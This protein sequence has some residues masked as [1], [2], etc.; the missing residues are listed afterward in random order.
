MNQRREEEWL[1]RDFDAVA[2][3]V[4]TQLS[5]RLGKVAA[6]AMRHEIRWE[7]KAV[8]P[9][10]LDSDGSSRFVPSRDLLL[11]IA[12]LVSLHRRMTAR[13]RTVPETVAVYCSIIDEMSKRPPSIADWMGRTLAQSS[14]IPGFFTRMTRDKKADRPP[15]KLPIQTAA[16]DCKKSVPTAASAQRCGII[17]ILE[18]HDAHELVPYC[19]II[20][21]SDN[22]LLSP[23]TSCEKC[24]A[25]RGKDQLAA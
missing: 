21:T 19:S 6:R 4:E 18:E 9:K 2:R 3:D 16:M 11:N 1:L 12:W 24:L 15:P 25:P 8:A 10:I 20:G 22:Q 17:A 14:F 23:C 13:G 7:F 5:E